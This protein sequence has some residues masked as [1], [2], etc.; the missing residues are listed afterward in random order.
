[1][2]VSQLIEALKKFDMQ[3]HAYAYED[4]IIIVSPHSTDGVRSELGYIPAREPVDG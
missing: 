4:S 1:M 2:T 3:A